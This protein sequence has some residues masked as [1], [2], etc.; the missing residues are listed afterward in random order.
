MSIYDPDKIVLNDGDR[1]RVNID[2]SCEIIAGS[3]RKRAEDGAARWMNNEPSRGVAYDGRGRLDVYQEGRRVGS[4][5][6][7]A[8]RRQAQDKRKDLLAGA[9]RAPGHGSETHAPQRRQLAPKL[10]R[11]SLNDARAKFLEEQWRR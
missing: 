5:A 6:L 7:D 9:W 3:S 1:M 8:Q 2:G 11:D 4:D 10:D